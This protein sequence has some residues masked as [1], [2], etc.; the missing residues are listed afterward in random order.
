VAGVGFF[1]H[2]IQTA[3][4]YISNA[5][6]ILWWWPNYPEETGM[7]ASMAFVNGAGEQRRN[8]AGRN[9]VDSLALLNTL[10]AVPTAESPALDPRKPKDEK[11]A[12][13]EDGTE[14]LSKPGG[15][16]ND[17]DNPRNP[18]EVRERH[19]QKIRP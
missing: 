16:R 5:R 9:L 13:E 3:A 12:E 17:P 1:L 4:F 2:R 10:L 14:S 15:F 18:N 6:R 11:Q 19:Q 8:R 7:H